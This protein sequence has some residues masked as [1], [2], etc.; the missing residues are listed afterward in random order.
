[1]RISINYI[2]RIQIQ[3]PEILQTDP[4]ARKKIIILISS[5]KIQVLQK[6]YCIPKIRTKRNYKY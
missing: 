1:M 6:I 2:I 4:D 5:P 3:D